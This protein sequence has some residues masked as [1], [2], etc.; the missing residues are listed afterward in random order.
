MIN[1]IRPKY[2]KPFDIYTFTGTV[3]ETSKNMESIVSGGGGGGA[4]YR[5]TG[6]TAPVTF[7]SRTV[8][9]DQFFLIDSD[10]KERSFQ[11]QDF[12]LAVRKGNL[13]TVYW[14]IVSGNQSGH[15]FAVKNHHTNEFFYQK[16][17]L[18][19]FFMKKYLVFFLIFSSLIAGFGALI[20]NGAYIQMGLAAGLGYMAWIRWSTMQREVENLKAELE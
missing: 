2:Q 5:G 16:E 11:L 19:N 12:N 1:T 7:T 8:I 4:T 18:K 10:G 9:H 3:E 20:S 14:G 6:G 17:V 15:Y 13:L